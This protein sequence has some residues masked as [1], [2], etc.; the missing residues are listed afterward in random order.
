M[1]VNRCDRR[2]LNLR[3]NGLKNVTDLFYGYFYENFMFIKLIKLRLRLIKIILQLDEMHLIK[4]ALLSYYLFIVMFLVDGDKRD[5]S[6][7]KIAI[8]E[9]FHCSKSLLFSRRYSL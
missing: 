6:L 1:Y 9:Y 3:Y 8:C 5:S 4:F 7:V 2:L